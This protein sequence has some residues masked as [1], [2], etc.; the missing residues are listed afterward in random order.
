MA[1]RVDPAKAKAAKQKKMAIGLCVMLVLVVAV[2]GPKTMTMLKGAPTPSVADAAPGTAVPAGQEAPPGV[3]GGPPATAATPAATPAPATAAGG[4]TG[5]STTPQTAVLVDS[6]AGVLAEEG[7]LLS[8]EQF[9]TKDPFKQQAGDPPAADPAAG[10]STTPASTTAAPPA[11]TVSTVP[12]NTSPP[13]PSAPGAVG[14]GTTTGAGP[15]GPGSGPGS[16]SS[17]PTPAATTTISVNGEVSTIAVDTP[18]PVDQPTFQ[19]VSVANDGKSVQIGIA[20]GDL[21]GSSDTVKLVRGK[22]VTLQNTADGSRYELVLLT[23]AGF[24]TPAQ[25]K[26]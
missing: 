11:V 17:A 24:V 13:G 26:N 1:K 4:I 5:T 16:G 2:Q 10:G 19:L 3:A 14:G 7:Q 18:F 23:V 15:S 22:K 12:T 6:D 9:A 25:S 21:S 20:G 8:F